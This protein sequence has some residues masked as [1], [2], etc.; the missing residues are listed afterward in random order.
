MRPNRRALIRLAPAFAHNVRDD[1]KAIR[2]AMRMLTEDQS[3]PA[4]TREQIRF[5]ND[6]LRGIT[7]RVRQFQMITNSEIRNALDSRSVLNSL[8]PLLQRLL[9]TCVF[10]MDIDPNLWPIRCPIGQLEELILPLA[11]NA[12]EATPRGGTVRIRARNLP[13]EV[14]KRVPSNQCNFPSEFVLIEVIDEGIGMPSGVL[15]RIF[16]PFFSTKGQGC[17]F[18]LAQVRAKVHGL[19]GELKAESQVGKGTVVSMLL[20][21]FTPEI[22]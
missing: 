3:I 15:N 14:Q 18:A 12:S 20:P 11:L 6:H 16:D 4:R 5:L 7:Q 13:T 8:E 22:H 9:D 17:G 21:R 1:V 19:G 10:Q 2:D